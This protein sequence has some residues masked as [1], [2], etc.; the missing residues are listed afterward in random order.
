MLRFVLFLFVL[1]A[2]TG[3]APA[4]AQIIVTG[5]A[6]SDVRILMS[7]TMH[8]AEHKIMVR[9][10]ARVRAARTEWVLAFQSTDARSDVRLVADGEAVTPQRIATDEEAPGG[11]TTLFFTGEDFYR[12]AFATD[13]E[14]AVGERTLSLPDQIQQDMQE[15]MNRANG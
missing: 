6:N 13:V 12:I 3:A 8:R 15:I 14:V 11:R 4:T 5:S 9:A 2:A 7:E 10:V 1:F